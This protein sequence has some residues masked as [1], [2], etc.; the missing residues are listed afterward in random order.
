MPEHATG[1]LTSAGYSV[2]R[3]VTAYDSL[4][5][6]FPTNFANYVT[7]VASQ[8]TKQKKAKVIADMMEDVLIPCAPVV[9][10]LILMDSKFVGKAMNFFNSDDHSK[11]LA[12]DYEQFKG[13]T[14][15]TGEV[16]KPL[17][18][19]YLQSVKMFRE[20]MDTMTHR[21]IEAQTMEGRPLAEFSVR[22]NSAIVLKMLDR[23]R[24][25]RA[26]RLRTQATV[27]HM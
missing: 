10:Q 13:A 1:L 26:E 4:A 17:I 25:A 18:A 23:M 8:D 14:L 20:M 11:K 2:S 19:E 6:T 22:E 21:P 15:P 3:N 16:I 7:E 9:A 27:L 5:L 12:D 24:K